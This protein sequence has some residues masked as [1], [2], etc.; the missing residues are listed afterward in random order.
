MA[1]RQGGVLC[2][3][4]AYGETEAKTGERSGHKGITYAAGRE[5]LL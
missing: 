5:Q 1:P 4:F 2:A 3:H